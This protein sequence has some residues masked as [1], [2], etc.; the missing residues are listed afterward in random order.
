MAYSNK[1]SRTGV[2]LHGVHSTDSTHVLRFARTFRSFDEE[3]GQ[4]QAGELQLGRHVHPVFQLTMFQ[5]IMYSQSK[6]MAV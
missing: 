3:I 2:I 6:Q 1:R 4:D 5:Y